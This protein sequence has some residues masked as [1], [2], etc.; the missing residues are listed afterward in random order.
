[1]TGVRTSDSVLTAI[2]RAGGS[3]DTPDLLVE[4]ASAPSLS[5]FVRTELTAQMSSRDT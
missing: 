2:V 1:M 4:A 5:I 3:T